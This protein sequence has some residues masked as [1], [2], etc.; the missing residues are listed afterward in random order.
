M[1]LIVFSFFLLFSDKNASQTH[2]HMSAVC[3][4]KIHKRVQKEKLKGTLETEL[5]YVCVLTT[6]KKEKKI[7]RDKK[8]RT[9]EK[10]YFRVCPSRKLI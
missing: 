7:E 8:D 9:R 4:I 2:V 3:V 5:V 10:S 6:Q 1:L